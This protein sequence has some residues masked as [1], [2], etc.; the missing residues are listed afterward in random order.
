MSGE[1]SL[2]GLVLRRWDQGESDR[3]LSVLTR[4]KGRILVTAKGARKSGSRL[5]S[6]SEPL[7]LATFQVAA[8]RVN[9]F[10]TQAQPHAGFGKLRADYDRLILGLSYAELVSAVAPL[11]HPNPELF[12]GAVIALKTIETAENPVVASI[13]AQLKLMEVEGISATWVQCAQTAGK[14]NENPAWVSPTAGGYV[15]PSPADDFVDGVLTSSE[16]LIGLDRL[17]GLGAPPPHMKHAAEAL[18]VLARFWEHH[19]GRDLPATEAALQAL[20]VLERDV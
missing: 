8:G 11:E 5:T 4:E 13:W 20:A 18:R 16:V 6:S 14:L 1:V 3:R 2:T 19:A 10:I 7:A 12:D 9:N 15:S 17:S